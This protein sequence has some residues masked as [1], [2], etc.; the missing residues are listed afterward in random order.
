MK[1]I[2]FIAFLFITAAL[3]SQPYIPFPVSGGQWVNDRTDYIPDYPDSLQSSEKYCLNGTITIDGKEYSMLYHSVYNLTTVFSNN[4]PAGYIREEDKVIYY[5]PDAAT[6]ENG[7]YN[8][9]VAPGDTFEL[10]IAIYSDSVGLIVDSIN[11]EF[12][13]GMDR[14]VYYLTAVF[15]GAYIPVIWYE[16]IGSSRGLL[17]EAVEDYGAPSVDL[18]QFYPDSSECS[19]Y[20]PVYDQEEAFIK[21][22]PDPAHDFIV[23]NSPD[24]FSAYMIFSSENKQISLSRLYSNTIDIKD[25]SSGI[26]YILFYSQDKIYRLKFIKF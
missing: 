16:G 2:S 11:N 24:N 19:V 9:N 1:T 22:Y 25:L 18:Q 3:F 12:S 23:V 6:N 8:F 21:L 10:Y 5:R 17:T 26:Y 13:F 15:G 20:L 14:K 4:S 7:I